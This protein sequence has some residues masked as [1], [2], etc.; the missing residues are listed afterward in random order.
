MS[1]ETQDSAGSSKGARIAHEIVYDIVPKVLFF[2]C[3]FLVIFLLFKL[4]VAQYSIQYT[5]FTR[6]AVAALILGK[7][8]PL[9]DWAVARYGVWKPRR[10]IWIVART[11]VYAFMVIALGTAEHLFVAYRE[12]RSLALAF[13]QVWSGAQGSHFL[14]LVLLLSLVVG[15]YLTAQEIDRALGAGGLRRLLLE[16]AGSR[17]GS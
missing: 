3:A 11:L 13:E 10:I 12:Q 5:A 7:V 17:G 6:A 4:F 8:V 1:P 15:A 16:P 2:F 14:G 9:L